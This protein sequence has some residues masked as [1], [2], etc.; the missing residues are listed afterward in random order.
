MIVFV[1]ETMRAWHG[2]LQEYV[3][4]EEN[5]I[6]NGHLFVAPRTY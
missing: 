3:C 1:Q 6:V 2:M 4:E 5:H